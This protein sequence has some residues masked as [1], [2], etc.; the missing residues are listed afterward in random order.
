MPLEGILSVGVLAGVSVAVASNGVSVGATMFT[1]ALLIL[2]AA[3][4]V[5]LMALVAL[6]SAFINNTPVV[7]MCVPLV[8]SWAQCTG[9]SPSNLLMPLGYASILGGQLT[10]AASASNLIV[11]GLYVES[12]RADGLPAP[13]SGLRFWG[14]AFVG[15]SAAL[16]G[17]AHRSF[18]FHKV[19]APQTLVPSVR[20]A[21]IWPL[22]VPFRP[23]P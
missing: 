15:L 5:R 19:G 12:R 21:P 1:G 23:G 3:A 9:V 13:S 11:M 17:I 14:S 16:I 4:Q 2:V 18:D 10:L 7:A 20:C 22:A 6:L 8:R